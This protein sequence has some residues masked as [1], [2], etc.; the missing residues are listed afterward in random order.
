MNKERAP[1]V[2]LTNAMHPLPLARLQAHASVR[3]APASDPQSLVDAAADADV[4]VVRA[5]LPPQALDGPR[6][7]GVVRHGAGLDMIPVEHASRLGIAVANVPQVNAVSVAEYAVGQM[8]AL[9]HRLR[10]ADATLRAQG[11]QQARQLADGSSEVA[12]K[13]VGIVGLGAI[14]TEVAR[15]CHHGLRAKVLGVRRSA[16]P[17]PPF[18]TGTSLE[19]LFAAADIVVLAC[20]LDDSTRGLVGARQLARMKRG[21]FLVN[22]SRGPV[23]DEDALVEALRH[24][25]LGGA[26]LD[27][28]REQ[29]LPPASPLLALP[30]VI[31]SPHLAG[32]T[33]DS[34]RRMGEG[35]VE[36][37]LQLLAGELPRHWVNTQAG[38]QVRARLAQLGST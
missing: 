32:I 13:V 12:G 37:V 4:I 26:A 25:P 28:F 24:G 18:V 17:M 9:A 11:W 7:R 38:A 29:P 36:Q 30:N 34:M 19:E 8:L 16:A 6:L 5:P 1:V 27:V 10:L 15:I 21:A 20:P 14:G 22:V 3:V 35:A 2:M 23:V 33:E 31:L